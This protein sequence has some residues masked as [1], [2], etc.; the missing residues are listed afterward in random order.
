MNVQNFQLLKKNTQHDSTKYIESIKS[1][2]RIL[3]NN[4]N[5][6]PDVK[7]VTCR[8]SFGITQ[9]NSVK[10]KDFVQKGL[11]SEVPNTCK[12]P[13]KGIKLNP[14]FSH[15]PAIIQPIRNVV[16]KEKML[17]NNKSPKGQIIRKTL[18][19]YKG[20]FLDFQIK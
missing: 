16:G 19:N 14:Y 8:A 2:A 18:N 11:K 3:S 6:N 4:N 20:K 12:I 10:I 5:I 15:S 7:F 9:K 1:K 13:S 17:V